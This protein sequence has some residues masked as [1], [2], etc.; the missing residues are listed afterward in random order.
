MTKKI[1][2]HFIGLNGSSYSAAIKVWGK[3][4]FIHKWHDNRSHGDINW[5]NDIIVFGSKA[6]FLPSKWTDQDHMRH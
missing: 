2:V 5:T 1:C 4:D 3:P 6:S